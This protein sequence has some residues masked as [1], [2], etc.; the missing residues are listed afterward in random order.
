M[1]YMAKAIVYN[2]RLKVLAGILMFLV[3]SNLSF[4]SASELKPLNVTDI[5]ST[6]LMKADI[7]YTQM[8]LNFVQKCYPNHFFHVFCS[9][10]SAPFPETGYCYE[11]IEIDTM[12]GKT[13]PKDT[14]IVT[15]RHDTLNM[16]IGNNQYQRDYDQYCNNLHPCYNKMTPF[17]RS[18]IASKIGPLS[19][20]EP[21]STDQIN[22]T[23]T[24][25]DK[26]IL[27]FIKNFNFPIA[28]INSTS[29]ISDS[30]LLGASVEISSLIQL[31]NNP[32][33]KSIDLNCMIQMNP[34]LRWS[35]PFIGA[36][37]LHNGVNG[38]S[39][40]GDGSL[41]GILDSGVG[42]ELY[43]DDAIH[44]AIEQE[45]IVGG[46]RGLIDRR[47]FTGSGIQDIIGH[48]T[49]IAGI[50]GSNGYGE[51]GQPT[52]CTQNI[53]VAPNAGLV[54]AKACVIP[55]TPENIFT[56][57][58]D[59]I[60]WLLSYTNTANVPNPTGLRNPVNIIQMSLGMNDTTVFDFDGSSQF[61]L[62]ADY[63][64]QNKGV[65]FIVA[66]GDDGDTNNL[67]GTPADAYNVI[68][69]GAIKKVPT[70]NPEVADYSCFGDTDDGRQSIELVAP[71]TEINS[72]AHH[73][74]N[75]PSGS[76]YWL[77]PQG[78]SD[79]YDFVICN[80]TS[81]AAPHV[82]GVAALME[83]VLNN[84]GYGGVEKALLT[85]A[86]LLN[87][88]EKLDGWSA[89][90]TK[91]LDEKQGAGLLNALEA[92]STLEN[93]RF[94]IDNFVNLD[95]KYYH[96]II[97]DVPTTFT[98][99]LVWNRHIT[100]STDSESCIISYNGEI[101]NNI[102]L[103]LYKMTAGASQATLIAESRSDKDN[104]EHICYQ[105]TQPGVYAIEVSP[106]S[107]V[108]DDY[109][110]TAIAFSHEKYCS[111]NSLYIN[112][113][114]PTSNA[115]IEGAYWRNTG[116]ININTVTVDGAFPINNVKLY[117]RYSSN[118]QTWQG[119]WNL[120]GTDT[121][122]PYSW[123][124]TWPNGQE[125]YY[126][127][128]TIA[129]DNAGN[130]ET[131]PTQPDYDV[132]YGYD[133]TIPSVFNLVTPPSPSNGASITIHRPTLDWETSYDSL[134]DISY[135]QILIDDSNTF[136]SPLIDAQTV[137]SQSIYTSG[138]YPSGVYLSDIT[139]YWK[140]KAFDH[141][142]NGKES[143]STWSF[144]PYT[145][146]DPP[147]TAH[148]S[149]Y[150]RDANTNNGIS[151]ATVDYYSEPVSI[152][153]PG[154][155]IMRSNEENHVNVVTDG[156]GYFDIYPVEVGPHSFQAT[157]NGVGTEII[158]NVNVPPNGVSLTFYLGSSGGGGG[159]GNCF[160][161][162]TSIT[163]PTGEINIENVK[164]G[165]NVLTYNPQIA[166]LE[167]K[168]VVQVYQHNPSDY[169]LI[170]ND[171]GI[172]A[173]HPI[174]SNNELIVAGELSIGDVLHGIN[175]NVSV[176]SIEHVLE[177][178]PV[179]NL[180]VADNHNFFA[181][182]ILVHNKGPDPGAGG[183]CPF[184]FSWNGTGFAV[185]NNILPEST[186]Y[187]RDTLDVVDYY[188]FNSPLVEENGV[189]PIQLY[190][191]WTERT[192]FDELQ[193]ITVDYPSGYNG[194]IDIGE[195]GQIETANNTIA[196]EYAFD[197][198][199]GNQ[200][201]MVGGS[202]NISYEGLWNDTLT[203]Y[204][205]IGQDFINPKL[206]VRHKTD[207]LLV[208]PNYYYPNPLDDP[209]LKSSIH[210]QIYDNGWVDIGTI[211]ARVN[212]VTDIVN[213]SS[214]SD[215]LK[216][217]GE[218]R[219]YITGRHYIDYI[220]LDISDE[221]VPC[222]IF[223]LAPISAQ[224]IGIDNTEMVSRILESDG[225]YLKLVP[226]Q[227]INVS[228]PYIP[229]NSECRMFALMVSG[230]YYTIPMLDI[231]QPVVIEATA[232]GTSTGNVTIMLE[233]AVG[234]T[235]FNPLLGQT[236]DLSNGENVNIFFDQDA[237]KHYRLAVTF[238]NCAPETILTVVISS[239]RGTRTIEFTNT[240]NST[241]YS[242]LDGVLWYV[243][244][245]KFNPLSGRYQVLRNTVLK[246]ET[247]EDYTWNLTD[248]DVWNWNFGDG[249]WTHDICPTHT[250]EDLGVYIL[251]LTMSNST[252]NWSYSIN[253]IIEVINEPPVPA[254]N[255]YQEVNLTLTV[256]GRK[257]N[258]V[259][260]RI[261]EDGTLIQSCDVMRTPGPPNSFTFELNKYLNSEYE[262][263]LVY[264]AVHKGSNPT[265]LQ[266]T[267][268]TTTQTFF[269]EFNTRHGYC[270]TITV[271][272]CYLNN[273]IIYNP[274]YWFDAS[275]SFDIDGEIVSCSWD[276]GDGTT[277][278]GTS[279]THSYAVSGEYLVTLTITDDDGLVSIS[280]V[281]VTCTLPTGFKPS[282]PHFPRSQ[283][284]PGLTFR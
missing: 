175:G 121:V 89:S 204:F 189:Y 241:I 116:T 19:S 111:G 18:F 106:I 11:Q 22:V 185:Q 49:H 201:W 282:P 150:V 254:I 82:S 88:A 74:A 53:G 67:V 133:S 247:N 41:V 225:N 135:Y 73:W 7:N 15:I 242:P 59:S 270:Q 209:N 191:N 83:P 198:E 3:I 272:E 232:I 131:A 52:E 261:Y 16:E 230:H 39:Y 214:V 281:T 127:F 170:N 224:Y 245:T 30:I 173:N 51:V 172:T 219:F 98:T 112:I 154:Q 28:F 161:S 165:D 157:K 273:A 220:G 142:G 195:D 202:D 129:T 36:S 263:E 119:T 171:L 38:I 87:S 257:D 128:R 160:I 210:I 57:Y 143:S 228:F 249:T 205:D 235:I 199:G 120:V 56:Q 44:P 158:H 196:P 237:E 166:N 113:D 227:Q 197:N 45:A 61:S 251:N 5:Q 105:I 156:N 208:K 169:L 92:M 137:S 256:S 80:G 63:T 218:I 13:S 20:S 102:N 81:M 207:F 94:D 212:W 85:K 101:L 269:K 46:Y 40:M 70:F 64:V 155:T 109:E 95:K 250:Y 174:Y 55:A 96:F 152:P 193:L 265:W 104:V 260:I 221:H 90:P 125:G 255:V 123:S 182:G 283:P 203:M 233:E 100:T 91:P 8:A 240:E 164:I 259:G 148:V 239:Q 211:P 108:S 48:G 117:Y 132:G 35:T 54:S 144:T 147:E 268:G 33:I 107:L 278:T 246:L 79:G 66:T 262:I 186:N 138:D 184:V 181:D 167:W 226:G 34:Q 9:S 27:H 124:F 6:E 284:R 72:T 86:I 222:D 21:T 238:D 162:G 75:S 244:G 177:V 266:F 149:G 271:P 115:H 42:V 248:C 139:Y 71:G 4:I 43:D 136:Q 243:T 192:N 1:H 10:T 267:S 118:N 62:F 114:Y 103:N 258:T 200:L 229:S 69:V 145:P 206:V 37:E 47:D 77:D 25:S 60:N 277:A 134:S 93:N 176:N 213:L 97:D 29:P 188:M 252:Y 32:Y 110:L 17:L 194:L 223:Y 264:D 146:A 12:P 78:Y 65:P 24:V 84:K 159:G 234:S 187:A 153:N 23:I 130:V 216:L 2:M 280:T 58:K 183:W 163:T 26:D 99:T 50:I 253:L 236:M 190:E 31:A 151:G 76:D 68:T 141:A 179:Y 215:Y 275:S 140:V 274:T 122:S 126:Q 180:E 231:I 14:I 178:K 168:P 279:V 217:G 276:F